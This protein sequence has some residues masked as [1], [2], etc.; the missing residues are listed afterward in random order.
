MKYLVLLIV[1]KFPVHESCSEPNRPYLLCLIKKDKFEKKINRLHNTR[2]GDLRS[3][4]EKYNFL[5]FI[6]LRTSMKLMAVFNAAFGGD[7]SQTKRGHL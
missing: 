1:F 2:T 5:C 7:G 4:M 6:T 3:P